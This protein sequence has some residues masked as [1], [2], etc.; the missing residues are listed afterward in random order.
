MVAYPIWQVPGAL[1]ADLA[2]LGVAIYC[3][4]KTVADFKGRRPWMGAFGTACSAISLVAG[5][6]AMFARVSP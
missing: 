1:A 6:A 4:I 2:I 5:L 3:V